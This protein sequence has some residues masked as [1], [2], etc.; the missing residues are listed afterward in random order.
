MA[1]DLQ[2]EELTASDKV[3][4]VGLGVVLYIIAIFLLLMI[5][6]IVALTAV[7][8]VITAIITLGVSLYD[9]LKLFSTS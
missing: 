6:P 3:W 5:S 2:T 9:K 7:I 8:A 4:L 1:D